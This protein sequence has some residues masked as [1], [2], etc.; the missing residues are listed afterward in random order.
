M[1]KAYCLYNRIEPFSALFLALSIVLT[2]IL[3]YVT[4]PAG[5]EPSTMVLARYCTAEV[6]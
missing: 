4:Q 3:Q 5:L 6:C 2:H 1:V